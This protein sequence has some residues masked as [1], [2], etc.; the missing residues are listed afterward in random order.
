M[1]HMMLEEDLQ[2]QIEAGRMDLARVRENNESDFLER[3]RLLRTTL[4]HLDR[5]SIV[6]EI[7]AMTV[8][9]EAIDRGEVE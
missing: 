3:L 8:L 4:D 7:V 6:G 9:V 5:D 1:T 2:A